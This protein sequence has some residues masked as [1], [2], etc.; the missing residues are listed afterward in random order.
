M[1]PATVPGAAETDAVGGTPGG[2]AGGSIAAMTTSVPV[3]RWRRPLL[4][5]HIVV[6][7]GA[8]GAALVMVAL[9]VAGLRGTD[10]RTVYPAAHLVEAWLIAPLALLALG[11]GVLQ[12]VLSRT[13][14]VTHVWVAAKLAITTVLTVVVLVVLE[15]ALADTAA[16]ALSARPLTGA[17]RLRI[18]LFPSVASVLLVVNVALGLYRPDRSRSRRAG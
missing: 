16:A 1:P 14:P 4:T 7:V 6:A 13:S 12:A 15:P 10:P 8:L 9:G 11:T 3:P 17:Q 2:R 5:A 18:A